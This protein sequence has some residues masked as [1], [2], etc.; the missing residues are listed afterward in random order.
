MV[1]PLCASVLPNVSSTVQIPGFSLWFFLSF[2]FLEQ[3]IVNSLQSHNI[4][5]LCNNIKRKSF[6][7]YA[8][9][10]IILIDV[11]IIAPRPPA[12]VLL[13]TRSKTCI[14]LR[15]F[16]NRIARPLYSCWWCRPVGDTAQSYKT[17]LRRLLSQSVTCVESRAAKYSAGNSCAH[18]TNRA[19]PSLLHWTRRALE[20]RNHREILQQQLLADMSQIRF[21]VCVCYGWCRDARSVKQANLHNFRIKCEN[22]ARLSEEVEA[23]YIYYAQWMRNCVRICIWLLFYTWEFRCDICGWVNWLYLARAMYSLRGT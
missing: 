11:N 17:H 20:W 21:I 22:V 23:I 18:D 2:L 15:V 6:E 9:I 10:S 5:A 4:P 7:L 14:F 3:R 8:R 12:K 19:Y 13:R 1:Q 16:V